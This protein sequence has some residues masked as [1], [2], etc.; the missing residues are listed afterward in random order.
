MPIQVQ[1]SS[2]VWRTVNN[3][4]SDAV[5]V[6]DSSGTTRNVQ[7]VWVKDSTS[8]KQVFQTSPYITSTTSKKRDMMFVGDSITWGYGLQMTSGYPYLVQQAINAYSGYVSSGWN[9]RCITS[10]DYTATPFNGG[11]SSPLKIIAYAGVAQANF[12][13]FSHPAVYAPGSGPYPAYTYPGIQLTTPGTSYIAFNVDASSPPNYI[14][15]VAYGSGSFVVYQE[16]YASPIAGPI[17]LTGTAAAYAIST[18]TWVGGS[19]PDFAI[20]LN[21]GSSMNILTLHPTN[22]YNGYTKGFI[23]VITA[24]RNS[25][26]IADYTAATADIQSCI[27]NTSSAG[28][29]APIYVLA[30]GTVSMYDANRAVS[31]PSVYTSQ[32]ST[33]YSGLTTGTNAGTVVL[34]LPPNP[35]PSVTFQATGGTRADYNTAIINLATSLGCQYVDLYNGPFVDNSGTTYASMTTANGC[36]Q[37]GL[38]PTALGSQ[39][40]ANRYICSLGLS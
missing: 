32:L 2:S 18:S 28:G 26:A 30:M 1:D 14:I 40:L 12:G 31:S 27:I 21:S 3:T 29:S 16:G 38:H 4:L 6:K 24:G 37:D 9:A 8:W 25:Y 5:A 10:D 7:S 19:N 33:I 22:I 36:Y 23:N 11:A 20:Y 35:D 13:P 15:I 34:T 39:L 17:T